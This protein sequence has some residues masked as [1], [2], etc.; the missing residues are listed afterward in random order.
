M[1]VASKKDNNK[2]DNS[3]LTLYQQQGCTL[4]A[5]KQALTHGIVNKEKDLARTFQKQLFQAA[6]Q[7]QYRL[8]L[9][10]QNELTAA[11]NLSLA[12][13]DKNDKTPDW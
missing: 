10:G 9:H 4:T 13:V 5:L 12:L 3:A 8:H 6:G 2:T 11:L 7:D 1:S